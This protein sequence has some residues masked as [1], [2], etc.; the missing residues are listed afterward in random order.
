MASHVT[1]LFSGW[2]GGR[3]ASCGTRTDD[4]RTDGQR[5]SGMVVVAS[6]V[7]DGRTD[8]RTDFQSLLQDQGGRAREL[9]FTRTFRLSSC[10]SLSHVEW[11]AHFSLSLSHAKLT[12]AVVVL[13]PTNSPPSS[14]Y[15][16]AS[17][18]FEET[19]RGDPFGVHTRWK[20]V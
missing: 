18:A 20:Y 2:H 16:V 5:F 15:S 8:G 3:G 19:R 4:G 10:L 7:T 11:I 1:N 14:Y 9:T 13:A 17:M 12:P 6:Y